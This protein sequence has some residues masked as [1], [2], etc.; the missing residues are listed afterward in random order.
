MR[1]GHGTNSD[2]RV[3]ML[4]AADAEAMHAPPDARL[5]TP[6]SFACPA[7]ADMPD[8]GRTIAHRKA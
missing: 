2:Q 6:L 5:S 3:A 1:C 7:A 4:R 8:L